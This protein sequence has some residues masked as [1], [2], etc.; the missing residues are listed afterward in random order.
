M[1]S[2]SCKLLTLFMLLLFGTIACSLPAVSAPTPFVF[3][4]PNLTMTALFNPPLEPNP[5]FTLLPPVQSATPSPTLEE[6]QIPTAVPQD[7]EAPTETPTLN[8]PTSAPTSTPVATQSNAGPVMR[9]RNSIAAIYFDTPPAIDGKLG[10]WGLDTYQIDNVVYGADRWR[11]PADLSGSVMV[12]WDE[13]Y[14]YLGFRVKDE[15]YVQLASGELLFKGDSVE[16]LLDADVSS[17]YYVR[18]L[19][20]DDYQVGISPGSPKPGKNTEA[21]LWFPKSVE[22][23]RS[24]VVIGVEKADNGYRLETAIPWSIFGVTP[25]EGQHFG[26]AAS[27][28]DNDKSGEA[29][30]QSMVSNVA[31]RRLTDPTTWGDLTLVNP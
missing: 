12:G 9:Q 25:E 21:Y 16:V 2:T 1:R 11:N 19:N 27:I 31:T 17:D 15:A 13:K 3:P 29:V 7:T 23:T 4:T 28:S 30:Q 8:L 14:L 5:T 24:K 6:V 22:G 20:N 10:D 26:F 18:A